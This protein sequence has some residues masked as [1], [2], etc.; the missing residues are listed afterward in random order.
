MENN[1]T[2]EQVP[3]ATPKILPQPPSNDNTLNQPIVEVDQT[4]SF[5]R[6]TILEQQNLNEK[7]LV[8]R[9]NYSLLLENVQ[10]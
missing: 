5:I 4:D 6:D 8:K 7:K 1:A 9:G 10:K 2:N 3:I